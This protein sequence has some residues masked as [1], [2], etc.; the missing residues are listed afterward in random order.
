LF[1]AEAFF[2]TPLFALLA[3]SA[4]I[5]ALHLRDHP[6]DRRGAWLFGPDAKELYDLIAKFRY[7]WPATGEVVAKNLAIERPTQ[8]VGD[9]R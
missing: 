6:E 2:G 4:W 1:Y 8:P 3:L 7:T 9:D 5:A